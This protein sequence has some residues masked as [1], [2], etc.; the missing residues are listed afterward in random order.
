MGIGNLLIA[1][2]DT[3]ED[4]NLSRSVLFRQSDRGRRKVDAAAE[5]VKELN[6]DVGVQ[7]WY[8]DINTE[9][10]QES[11]P[12]VVDGVLGPGGLDRGRLRDVLGTAVAFEIDGYAPDAGHAWSVVVKG[13]ADEIE[14]VKRGMWRVVNEPGGTA[15]RPMLTAIEG[16]DCD[17]VVVVVIRGQ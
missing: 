17:R 9:R 13:T 14:T 7:A 10:G 8:G 2:F 5:R 4:A 11:T 12:V 15:G 16:Q 6:A 1:D 3:I